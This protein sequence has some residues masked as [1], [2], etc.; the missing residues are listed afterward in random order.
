MRT[1]S[2]HRASSVRTSSSHRSTVETRGVPEF[3]R[4]YARQL[5]VAKRGRDSTARTSPRA[6]AT[7][8]ASAEAQL[9]GPAALAASRIKDYV[10]THVTPPRLPS[11][12]TAGRGSEHDSQNGDSPVK[13]ATRE[14]PP[15]AAAA[16]AAAAP[17]P[18]AKAAVSEA[19]SPLNFTATRRGTAFDDAATLAAAAASPS[20]EGEDNML[21]FVL[22]TVLVVAVALFTLLC[23]TALITSPSSDY[24]ASYFSIRR[25]NA[26]APVPR[27]QT[28]DE[29]LA[30]RGWPD[31]VLPEL[32]RQVALHVRRGLW[33]AVDYTG[34][35]AL[36]RAARS[37]PPKIVAHVWAPVRLVLPRMDRHTHPAAL[38]MSSNAT[39]GSEGWGITALPTLAAS[40]AR[41]VVRLVGE[42]LLFAG[43]AMAA[44]G[45]WLGGSLAL[46]ST[47]LKPLHPAPRNTTPV[48]GTA[49]TANRTS[50]T[51]RNAS[52]AL[53]P[54]WRSLHSLWAAVRPTVTA[55]ANTTAPLRHP[56]SSA[57]SGSPSTTAA[58]AAADGR[59]SPPSSPPQRAPPPAVAEVRTT[60][61][62][63]LDGALWSSVLAAHRSEVE[64]LAREDV[65]EALGGGAAATQAVEVA[66]RVDNLVTD[67]TVVSHAPAELATPTAA[68]VTPPG[69]A[70]DTVG[71]L[72]STRRTR[73]AAADAQLR[74]WHFPR[75]HAFYQRAVEAAEVHQ[76]SDGSGAGA[77]V[78][79]D[80]AAA[81]AAAAACA[82]EMADY[83][84]HCVA[85]QREL[86]QSLHSCLDN[87]SESQRVCEA[88]R[89][90]AESVATAR[91]RECDS[92]LTSCRA[93]LSSA[94]THLAD[95]ERRALEHQSD[96]HECQVALDAAQQQAARDAIALASAGE[97]D[98]EAPERQCNAS[99]AAAASECTRR[100]GA[101][102]RS[103]AQEHAEQLAS[104]EAQCGDRHRALEAELLA[105][106]THAEQQAEARCGAR[107]RSDLASANESATAAVTQL[108]R[109]LSAAEKKVE[110]GAVA[111][112]GAAERARVAFAAERAQLDTA[113][114]AQLSS[115][116]QQCEATERRAAEERCAARLATLA[117]E[118]GNATAAAVQA[119]EASCTARLAR[120]L[121]AL[122]SSA[123]AEAEKLRRALH[124]AEDAAQLR[125]RA[126]EESQ[127]R[128]A[129]EC[130]AAQS[131]QRDGCAVQLAGAVK[132]AAA[133]VERARAEERAAQQRAAS[134][135]W[136]LEETRLAQRC[137][138][139]TEVAVTE[140]SRQLAGDHARAAEEAAQEAAAQVQQREEACRAA[141]E[142]V[143]KRHQAQVRDLGA[144]IS[145][146]AA[147]LHAAAD[148]Q[149]ESLREARRLLGAAILESAEEACSRVPRQGRHMCDAVRS[150]IEEDLRNLPADAT[151]ADVVRLV[152]RGNAAP[153]AL[154]LSIPAA[155]RR[156]GVGTLVRGVCGVAVVAGGAYV[157]LQRDRR[158]RRRF[159]DTVAARVD[160]LMALGAMRSAVGRGGRR[161]PSAG[162]AAVD[163][164]VVEACVANGADA[165]LAW[166]SACGAVLLEQETQARGAPPLG[167]SS[168]SAADAV[169]ALSATVPGDSHP[170]A[171]ARSASPASVACPPLPPPPPGED[172]SRLSQLHAGFVQGYY[173]ML[174]MYYVDLLNAVANRELAESQLQEV[175]SVATRQAAVLHRQSAVVAQLKQTLAEKESAATPGAAAETLAKAERRATAQRETIALLEGQLRLTREE[176][177]AARGVVQTPEPTPRTAA[178]AGGQDSSA[179]RQLR[180]LQEIAD[181][182][183]EGDSANTSDFSNARRGRASHRDAVTPPPVRGHESPTLPSAIKKTTMVRHPDST[184]RFHKL[185]W[186][187]DLGAV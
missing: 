43:R 71:T 92:A 73:Q 63:R 16:A 23:A 26:A 41:S 83:Q 94:A 50:S 124:S 52:T 125:A 49:T 87:A 120:E 141:G 39:R 146:C 154:S 138:A 8:E 57:T 122:N 105:K 72:E 62:C 131:R 111:C 91:L 95:Q 98:A 184:R 33:H 88:A 38:Y 22:K 186:Q 54:L 109:A 21:L 165:L 35:P 155:A 86:E 61:T 47:P 143:L 37:L 166:H 123:S 24:D 28:G 82:A 80:T 100:V 151:A 116:K 27:P 90:A 103:M 106:A 5:S 10:S 102:R 101:A 9:H 172:T 140:A 112:A 13:A 128:A 42:P 145:T 136:K 64:R 108:R 46:L 115:T 74:Q 51:T 79:S 93:D 113:C 150:A 119:A 179:S 107:L 185:Q 7:S 89:T 118:R 142:A 36:L 1:G 163:W 177:D 114:T 152:L 75:L 44:L 182:G 34:V 53:L 147:Q 25:A 58:D 183:A 76:A 127:Q 170:L 169:T 148:S 12:S 153:G 176:L 32:P 11:V 59:R 56:P 96:H 69:D 121:S 135:S 175:E 178:A 40:V 84:K 137:A 60:H 126:F 187:D 133:S 66:L 48:A 180:S 30:R 70:R 162:A 14:P 132:D 110:D 29:A 130:E 134:E 167:R 65:W 168:P 45:R 104:Q 117:T 85:T 67:I 78:S 174:E 157:L 149:R 77:S 139:S 181:G 144:Q 17:A 3:D 68:T 158:R 2:A 4:E 55:P 31:R 19:S 99:L 129:T 173:G 20:A 160:E 6:G 159:E 15:A 171:P 81:A 161:L 97:S 164:A 156:G 18:A